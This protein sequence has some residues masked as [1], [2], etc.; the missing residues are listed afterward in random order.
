MAISDKKVFKLGILTLI[1]YLLVRVMVFLAFYL[2]FITDMWLVGKKV[3]AVPFFTVL[4]Q[5]LL[6]GSIAIASFLTAFMAEKF[7][8]MEKRRIF[9]GYLIVWIICVFLLPVLIYY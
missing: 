4:E 1:S 9:A 8:F 5:I 7:G 2:R 6:L 3:K